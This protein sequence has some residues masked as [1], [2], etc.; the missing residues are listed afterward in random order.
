MKIA[1]L[2]LSVG[3]GGA[4]KLL[5]ENLPHHVAQGNEVTM[6][7]LSSIEEEPGYIDIL[8]KAGVKLITL[9]PGGFL[10]P[11]LFFRLLK[12]IRSNHFDILHVHLFPCIYYASFASRFLRKFPVLVVT[13]HSS[14]NRRQDKKWLRPV[15]RF[16][17]QKY[18][19]IIAVS[20][21]VESI[22]KKTL[23]WFTKK[24]ITINNG[25]NLE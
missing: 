21:N 19:S 20:K 3:K 4:E 23:P 14:V 11:I 8:E 15:E 17:F 1:H 25:I 10:N 18:D 9:S 7:Q 12:T 5:V 16:M 13:E 6:I 2:C 24:I 22:I